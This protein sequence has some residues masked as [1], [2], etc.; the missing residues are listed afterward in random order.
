MNVG[1]SWCYSKKKCHF[2]ALTTLL[3]R[4]YHVCVTFSLRQYHVHCVPT[5]SLLR[6]HCVNQHCINEDCT[7]F[8]V[9]CYCVNEDCTTFLVRCYCVNEDCT[10]FLVRCYCV[11]EDCTTFLVRCYCIKPLPRQ[12]HEC[13]EHVQK[14][15]TTTTSMQTVPRP[16]CALQDL[17]AFLLRP[18]RPYCVQCI[19]FSR[20]AVVVQSSSRCE[21]GIS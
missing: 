2:H 16:Y 15:S 5:T 10:T 18:R 21:G 20:G 7:T 3:S 11:N 1:E 14:L 9:R 12:H 19:F 6:S 13:F 17:T 4:L 8:L